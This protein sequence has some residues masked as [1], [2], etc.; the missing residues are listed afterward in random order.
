[1][2]R[3]FLITLTIAVALPAL[4]EEG[5]W[6]LDQ[7]RTDQLASASDIRIT[8]A[9][10][11]RLRHAPVRILAGGSGGTG[12]FASPNGLILTNHHVALDCIRTSTL[13]ESSDNFVENGF[14]ATSMAEE[15]PC[16][17]FLIQVERESR[18]VTAD[19]DSVVTPEMDAVGIQQA[20]QRKRSELERSCQQEKGDDYGC[21][22][23]DFNSGARSLLIV[24]EELK[25][26]RLVY[27]PELQLGYFGGDEMNFRFPRYVSDI[28]ILRA[29]VAKDGAH[30]EYD[31]A[32]VP[33]RPEHYFRVSFEGIEEGDFTLVA[34]FPG[35]TNRYRMS[36]SA[37][38][39]VR[40]GIPRRNEDIETELELLRGYASQSTE[41]DVLLKNRIFGLANTLKYQ[42]DVLK[43]LKTNDVVSRFR[44]R[45]REFTNFL[46][47]KPELQVSFG[48]ILEDQARVYAEDVEANDALD[49]AIQWLSRS[50]VLSY[51]SGL[52]Q[53]ALA[54][55]ESSDAEREPQFQ[56]RNWPRVRQALANEDPI[57]LALDADYL[58]LGFELAMALQPNQRI[59]AVEALRQ[60]VGDDPRKLAAAVLEGTEI[61]AVAT[62]ERLLEASA[63][64][65]TASEDAAIAFARAMEPTFQARRQRVRVLNEKL[66]MHRA[67]FSRGMV[68]WKGDDLYYDANFTLRAAFGQA[69]S[70]TDRQGEKL[71]LA[72]RFEG[73]FRLAEQRGDTGEF[74]LPNALATW[75]ESIGDEAF[76]ERYADLPVN[77]VTTNDTTGGNSGSAILDSQLRVVG[78]LFDGN[79]DSMA[80]DW[81]YSE[82]TGRAIA[83][84]IRFALTVARDVHG[85]G[86]IVDELT[87]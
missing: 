43:A 32:N 25:D 10:K 59:A 19:M 47:G 56:E 37:D 6:R 75:R 70:Y 16:R 67:R 9:D 65:L 80:S 35:N 68:A 53:F 18:D 29:Y 40:R 83:T 87:K 20:R 12:S 28:S 26:V 3:S 24:Y 21:E 55:A 17:R 5:M 62:R 66:F 51:A 57:I 39:N 78:L 79:E 44:E 86:W 77:F 36:H 13:A 74:A 64:E 50:S 69:K 31:E 11:K 71:P 45:E 41:Y 85:A 63:D 49:N 38:Y 8:E 54:R 73:L 82:T 15:L 7:L 84:D 52:Y 4:A 22:V 61:P 46:E 34:G 81:I 30:R 60:R 72:T 33:Y 76:R 48:S 2:K 1:M 42:R 14:S 58:A 23:A 27:A